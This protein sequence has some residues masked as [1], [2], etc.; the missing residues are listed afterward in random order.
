MNN[1]LLCDRLVA[2]R[3][4]LHDVTVCVGVIIVFVSVPF[5]ESTLPSIPFNTDCFPNLYVYS[6]DISVLTHALI[7][8]SLSEWQFWAAMVGIFLGFCLVQV[9]C[10]FFCCNFCCFCQFLHQYECVQ[11]YCVCR[12]PHEDDVKA[13]GD[14]LV[15][16][17]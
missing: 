2:W 3:L 8:F 7:Y 11:R 4:L 5:I 17:I 13:E 10:C 12:C 16:T 1:Q 6:Y 14:E 9:L 15:N